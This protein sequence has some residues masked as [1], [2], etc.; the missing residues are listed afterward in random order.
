MKDRAHKLA[1]L[2]HVLGGG[3]PQDL[4]AKP[5][6]SLCRTTDPLLGESPFTVD[7]QPVSQAEFERCRRWFECQPASS[8]FTIRVLLEDVQSD[9]TGPQEE[10]EIWGLRPVSN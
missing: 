6:Q 7:G 3:N 8:T 9:A 4:P 2:R 10:W 1:L 5:V